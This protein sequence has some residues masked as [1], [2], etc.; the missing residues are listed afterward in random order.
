MNA[1]YTDSPLFLARDGVSLPRYRVC[2]HS[3]GRDQTRSVAFTDSA[4]EAVREFLRDRPL[5]DGSDL[6]IW[7]RHHK[8]VVAQIAWADEPT[9]FGSWLRVRTNSFYDPSLAEI[10]RHLCERVEVRR[11]IVNGVA[12]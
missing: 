3:A 11:A 2:L 5:V 7:D 10:A 6:Y 4:T 1:P 8:Q 12:V 9:T